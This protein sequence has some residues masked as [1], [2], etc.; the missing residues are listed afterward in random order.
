MWNKKRITAKSHLIV[1]STTQIFE[2]HKMQ[3]NFA[4][5]ALIWFS[6]IKRCETKCNM[7]FML[8]EKIYTLF[9]QHIIKH[10]TH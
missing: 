1:F 8:S 5:C 10:I 6:L 7:P 3:D 9:L 4:R 2:Y